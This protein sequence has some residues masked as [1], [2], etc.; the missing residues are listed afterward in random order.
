MTKSK[1]NPPQS[2]DVG[3]FE[4]LLRLDPKKVVFIRVLTR[5]EQ[6]QELLALPPASELLQ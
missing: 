5:E 2:K 6:E 1:S 4:D 3:T